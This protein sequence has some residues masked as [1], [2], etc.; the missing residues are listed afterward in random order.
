MRRVAAIATL[1]VG[2]LLFTGCSSSSM[3][4][5]SGPA[6]FPPVTQDFAAD[7][8]ESA[9]FAAES[10]MP[11][12]RQV[13]VTGEMSL[14][15]DQP[16]DAAEEA[17]SIVQAAGGHV[18]SRYEEP[19][20]DTIRASAHLT[21]RIPAS[22]LDQTITSLKKLGTVNR[23]QLSATD[24][25]QQAQ[26]MDARITALE[27]SVDRL[28]DLMSRASDTTD[29][30]TIEQALS[31]RQANLESMQSQ[32]KNLADQVSLSTLNLDL[33]TAGT[34]PTAGPQNFWTGLV[35]GWNALVAAGAGLLIVIGVA[36]PWLAVAAVV[37][38]GIWLL[39]RHLSRRKKA[40][41]PT[42]PATPTP[43]TAP[44]PATALPAAPG[45]VSTPSAD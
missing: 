17:V 37:G 35:A 39:V 28:L 45:T 26:D 44:L 7:G 27:T 16:I 38:V 20:S 22:A 19:G 10:Q 11:V 41:T 23:V 21:L 14:T 13:I 12:D 43:P 3:D 5:S 8:S 31:E 29:L 30:I 36:L 2:M 40:G 33:V 34:V 4:S 18:D 6:G 24:V 25:T 9:L 32:R 42:P 1:A 15:V